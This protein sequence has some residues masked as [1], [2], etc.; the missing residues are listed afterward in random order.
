VVTRIHPESQPLPL[1]NIQALEKS[2]PGLPS[3]GPCSLALISVP[4]LS[5]IPP[6]DAAQLLSS[7]ESV[8]S[9][10]L[11]SPPIVRAQDMI[12]IILAGDAAENTDS[13]ARATQHSLQTA[14]PF[15]GGSVLELRFGIAHTSISATRSPALLL[16][17]AALEQALVSVAYH[18]RLADWARDH[19]TFIEVIRSSR[20]DHSELKPE[21]RSLAAE[22][23]RQVR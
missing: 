2:L 6:P 10:D 12:L 4:N 19:K 18:D 7:L 5:R 13:L 21:F 20:T 3:P 22:L 17:H 16:Y 14:T 11:G 15:Q 23:R 1:A 9:L 8:L